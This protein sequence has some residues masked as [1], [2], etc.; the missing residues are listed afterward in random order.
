[1]NLDK[2]AEV[3]WVSSVPP[4]ICWG[5]SLIIILLYSISSYIAS[6]MSIGANNKIKLL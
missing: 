3:S 5:T 2:L 4:G 6:E 1:L